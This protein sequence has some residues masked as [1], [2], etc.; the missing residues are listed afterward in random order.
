MVAD[1]T[2]VMQIAILFPA[3]WFAAPYGITA[4]A[5]AQV[6]GEAVS[7]ALLGVIAGR[8]LGI[9]LVRDASPRPP[10]RWPSRC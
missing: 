4:V 8:V 7:L 2:G 10:P 1:A 9:P 3:I 5:A 6:G